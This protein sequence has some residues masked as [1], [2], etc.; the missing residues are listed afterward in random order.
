M[1]FGTKVYVR[2]GSNRQAMNLRD[3]PGILV[4]ARGCDCAVKLLADD[5][6]A[7]SGIADKKGD[8]GWW[9]RSVVTK[10]RMDQ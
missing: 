9:S 4:G 5:P 10:M 8:I 3:V 7:T 1:R 2:R 6:M